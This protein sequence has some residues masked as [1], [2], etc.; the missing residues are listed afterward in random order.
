MLTEN[1]RMEFEEK[2][3][4]AFQ[5]KKLLFQALTHSSFSNECRINKPK[6]NERLEFL[7]DA[8]LEVVS[9]DFLFHKYPEMKE[10]KLTKLRASLVCEPALAATAREI[11]IGSYLMLGRGEEQTGGGKRD[12]ILSDA[13]ESVIGAIY[14]DQ[15]LEPARKFIETFILNDIER[16]SLFYDSKTHLQELVQGT[17]MQKIEYCVTG[18]RGPSH[19]KEFFVTVYIGDR[20]AGQGI[21]RSKK[22]AEQEAAYQAILALKEKDN[23]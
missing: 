21:G 13:V 14:L 1:K 2:I 9:S 8:V 16:K 4:Y 17:T 22:A 15:G 3:H 10:G 20:A 6:D 19:C 11:S 7:G 18:E 23:Q 5:N 12:S